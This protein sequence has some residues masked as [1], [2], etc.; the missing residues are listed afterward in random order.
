MYLNVTTLLF[1]R[2]I[3]IWFYSLF[4]N[5]KQGTFFTKFSSNISYK[6]QETMKL[7]IKT[8]TIFG[9][10]TEVPTSDK[11]KVIQNYAQRIVYFTFLVE[12]LKENFVKELSTEH[13]LQYVIL[14]TGI[15]K[16]NSKSRMWE[17]NSKAAFSH[18]V[19]DSMEQYF[20]S[21][22]QKQD[23]CNWHYQFTKRKLYIYSERKKVYLYRTAR[24]LELTSSST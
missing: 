22:S 6:E 19:G 24:Q 17:N 8:R 20:Y 13:G 14:Y 7:T 2:M 9:L 3:E 12:K 21:R 1:G 10:E 11:L 4:V 23:F 16:I 18:H 15:V 5:S